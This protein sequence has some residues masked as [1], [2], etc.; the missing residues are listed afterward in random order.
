M[1][2][3]DILDALDKVP[4]FRGIKFTD[5]N[6]FMLD[7][8]KKYRPDITILT[9][10]DEMAVLTQYFGADGNIGAL[11]GITC[12][13]YKVMWQ[14]FLEGNYREARE[15]Q[16]RANEMVECYARPGIGSLPGIKAVF[17]RIYGIPAGNASPDGPFG[18]RMPSE[19][20]T[21]TLIRVFRKNIITATYQ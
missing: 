9:G 12:Y 5:T 15:L 11:Q 20:D 6:F 7:R 13:H 21:Q 16:Y 1:A 19:E 8:F 10:A 3:A 18:N 14:K 4:T 17:D 2:A